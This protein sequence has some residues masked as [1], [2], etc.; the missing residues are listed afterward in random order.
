[1]CSFQTAT[2]SN[3]PKYVLCIALLLLILL[4]LLLLLLF[5][6][7]L[8]PPWSQCWRSPPTSHS[9]SGTVPAPTRGNHSGSGGHG[10]AG[11]HPCFGMAVGL[12][13]GAARSWSACG[14]EEKTRRKKLPVETCRDVWTWTCRSIYRCRSLWLLWMYIYGY[15]SLAIVDV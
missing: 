7:V 15:R 13:L 4:I 1:M 2:A 12:L 5:L 14:L 6:C 8:L 10:H 3:R 9:S 11:F